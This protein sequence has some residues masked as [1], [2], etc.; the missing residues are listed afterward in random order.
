MCGPKR[1]DDLH[2]RDLAAHSRLLPWFHAT[3]AAVDAELPGAGYTESW[4][5]RVSAGRCE[6]CLA[7]HVLYLSPC[8]CRQ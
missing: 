5:W 8:R 2:V 7:L 6:P 3:V 1:G 4:P